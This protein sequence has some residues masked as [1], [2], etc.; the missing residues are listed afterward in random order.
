MFYFNVTMNSL[1]ENL[2]L[3]PLLLMLRFDVPH[4]LIHC[5]SPRIP[6]PAHFT[7]SFAFFVLSLTRLFPAL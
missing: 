4:L 1:S 7:P 6:K 3:L 2:P 5:Q